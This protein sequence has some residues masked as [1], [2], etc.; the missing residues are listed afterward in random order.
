MEIRSE[1]G[2]IEQARIKLVDGDYVVGLGKSLNPGIREIRGHWKSGG[3]RRGRVSGR[4][5]KHNRRRGR[6][7][8]HQVVERRVVRYRV[9]RA[10]HCLILFAKELLAELSSKLWTPGESESRS[11]VVFVGRKL[12]RG[13]NFQGQALSP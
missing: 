9:A 7:V 3:G 11:P 2:L 12:R 5:E 1:P 8:E 6:S 13:T 4:V 10:N